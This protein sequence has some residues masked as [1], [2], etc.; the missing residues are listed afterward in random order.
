V[1]ASFGE[2]LKREREK[3]GMTLEEVSGV[4]KISV[5]NLKALELEKFD[6]LP[7]GIFN[8]GF[9]RAYAKHLGLD[10]EQVVADY[11]EA[12]GESLPSR[13]EP[14]APAEAS[15]QSE[16]Q[17]RLSTQVP[18][19][20]LAALLVLGTLLLAAW[21]HYSHRKAPVAGEETAEPA[22]E[23]PQA[24]AAAVPNSG[25][26]NNSISQAAAPKS[27]TPKPDHVVSLKTGF[28]ISLKARDEVWVSLALDGKPSAESTLMPGQSMKV[29]ASNQVIL[30]IG[31]AA[32]LAV[33][34][35]GQTV[36]VSGAEGEVRTLTFTPSGLQAPDPVAPQPN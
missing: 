20:S 2:R 34:F 10:E 25:S 14:G 4:T 32:G 23:T 8:R 31:N 29:H 18:W 28:D 21:V 36:P 30:K 26:A 17:P 7:G 16:E 13:V 27:D 11:L 24:S 15:T 5:R 19:G 9:V 22:V 6:Q 1:A 12:S 35:N 33:S 3:R